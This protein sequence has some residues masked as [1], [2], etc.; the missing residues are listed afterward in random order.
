MI[1]RQPVDGVSNTLVPVLIMFC[2]NWR[3]DFPRSGPAG[4]HG[5]QTPADGKPPARVR[6]RPAGTLKANNR[7]VGHSLH[8]RLRRTRRSCEARSGRRNRR[9]PSRRPDQL[10][11]GPPRGRRPSSR[12][13]SD[14]FRSRSSA[15]PG[16]ATDRRASVGASSGRAAS[17]I[18]GHRIAGRAGTAPRRPACPPAGHALSNIAGAMVPREM[19]RV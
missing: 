4:G 15:T 14:Q 18:A 12:R 1:P 9:P 7:V 17:P 16:P 3:R 8:R 10:R 5:E 2:S 6:N 19:A 13:S 11:G